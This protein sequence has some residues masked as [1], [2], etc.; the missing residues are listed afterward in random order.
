MERKLEGRRVA[1]LVTGGFEQVELVEPRKALDA[2]GAR[3]KIVSPVMGMVQAMNHDEKG[4]KFPV[5]DL[6]EHADPKAYDALLLPGGVVNSDRLRI[7]PKAISFVKHFIETGKPIAAICH[8]PW[9]LIETASVRGRRLTSW[10]TL[11]TD[12]VNAGANWQDLEVVVDQGL[13][14]SRKPDDIPAF[15]AKMIE[16]FA[17]GRHAPAGGQKNPKGPR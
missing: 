11:T 2:A 8:A 13:V 10:P 7:M 12:L 14:T 6:L 4:D 15:N 16:E 17:E 1:I 9:I 5:D 3:T